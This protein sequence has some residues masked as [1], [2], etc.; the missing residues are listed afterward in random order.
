MSLKHGLLGLINHSNSIGYDID[1]IFKSTLCFFWKAQTSQIYRELN[2]LREE[3]FITEKVIIQSGKPNKKLLRITDSGREELV[4]WLL[5]YSTVR[6]DTELRSPVLM[7]VFFNYNVSVKD[8]IEYFKALKSAC[9]LALKSSKVAQQIV[10]AGT[11]MKTKTY[12]QICQNYGH[13]YIKFQLNWVNESLIILEGLEA[14]E[15]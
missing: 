9:E 13:N 3:G 1:K 7:K 5:D 8:T 14:K 10:D 11:N 4:K 12:Y 2:N 15:N 6:K